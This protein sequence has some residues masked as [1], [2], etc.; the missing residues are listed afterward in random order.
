MM[1]DGSNDPLAW[2]LFIIFFVGLF[3]ILSLIG[4]GLWKLVELILC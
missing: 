4:L 3:S 2:F 1:Y